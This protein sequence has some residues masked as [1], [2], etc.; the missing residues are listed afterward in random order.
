M[1]EVIITLG[2]L[3]L[4]MAMAGVSLINMSKAARTTENR[5]AANDATRG[6][7]EQISRNIRAANPI[8]V[9]DPISVYDSQVSFEV[10]CTPAG[11]GTCQGTGLR[12]IVYSIS[13]NALWE[14]TNGGTAV[15]PDGPANNGA[16]RLIL[17]P[18]A[19]SSTSGF[20]LSSRQYAIV[21]T[22]TEPVFTYF[23]RDGTLPT[24][25]QQ[26]HDCTKYVTVR[27]KV[28]TETGNTRTPADLST[29]V[30]LRNYNEVSNCIV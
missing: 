7:L 13:A 28:I 4:V 11:S 17:G 12:R 27:L 26:F 25:S 29:T 22:A 23:K 5:S 15:D 3:S 21:N 30:T 6:A 9:Q 2:V 16:F 20:P 14:S 10:F 19:Q 18:I 24:S 8:D 1:V